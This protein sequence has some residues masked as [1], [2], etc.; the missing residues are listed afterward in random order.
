[1]PIPQSHPGD[2]PGPAVCAGSKVTATHKALRWPVRNDDPTCPSRRV[3]HA[4]AEP[5]E[6]MA[7]TLRPMHRWRQAWGLQRGTGRPRRVDG[8]KT[9]GAAGAARPCHA[10]SVGCGRARMRRVVA[11]TWG[12][13]RGHSLAAARDAPLSHAASR[14]RLAPGA[15]PRAAAAAAL[16]SAVWCA[17]GGAG[18][19]DGV[20]APRA[21]AAD[22]AW[23]GLAQGN[24]DAVP[25]AT[26]AHRCCWGAATRAG[27]AAGRPACR[28]RGAHERRGEARAQAAGQAHEA[29][30]P[31]GGR[32]RRPHP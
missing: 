20:R 32:T 4:S 15:S 31:H 19:P 28:R 17:P 23:P 21:S 7:V 10:V 18:D 13:A 9:R 5:P 1:M 25:G 2:T 24:A 22:A 16:P 6:P 14:R 12:H 8:Q 29:G 3:L 11:T 30:P 27:A 26:R